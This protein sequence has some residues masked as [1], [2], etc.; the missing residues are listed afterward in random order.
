METVCELPRKVFK[1]NPANKGKLYTGGFFAYARH[2]NFGAY[3]LWR[4]GLATFCGGLGWGVMVTL[5]FLYYFGN[6]GVPDID[7]HM[8]AKVR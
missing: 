3:L 5:Y 8:S 1:S 2:I 6:T 4:V 7:R